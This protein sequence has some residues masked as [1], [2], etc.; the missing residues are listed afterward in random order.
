MIAGATA[1]G[2]SQP[3]RAQPAPGRPAIVDRLRA[4]SPTAI[5]PRATDLDIA[6]ATTKKCPTS[7]VAH[8]L[9]GFVLFRS[10][11]LDDALKELDAADSLHSD[12]DPALKARVEAL[13]ASLRASSGGAPVEDGAV[14]R[15]ASSV[16]VETGAVSEAASG[17]CS[18]GESGSAPPGID[19]GAYDIFTGMVSA[20]CNAGTALN[21]LSH[22]MSNQP[23]PAPRP[24]PV[25]P[26]CAWQTCSNEAAHDES[27]ASEAAGLTLMRCLVTCEPLRG[28]IAESYRSCVSSCDADWIHAQDA[29]IDPEDQAEVKACT[30]CRGAPSFPLRVVIQRRATIIHCEAA[31][32]AACGRLGRAVCTR[33]M[34]CGWCDASSQCLSGSP[35]GPALGWRACDE[36]H[37]YYVDPSFYNREPSL[38]EGRGVGVLTLQK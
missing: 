38:C 35:L 13:R 12:W 17:D 31:P 24:K 14:S 11:R 10:A 7:S 37:W 29:V 4:C 34:G 30:Q 32:A 15:V 23:A 33:V 5:P 28:A 3:A 20:G 6:I 16:P 18:M 2:W 22:E 19:A 8:S 27:M 25:I 36:A 1:S 9:L 21:D 26:N